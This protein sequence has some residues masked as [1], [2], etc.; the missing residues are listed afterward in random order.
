[1]KKT[2]LTILISILVAAALS[3]IYFMT[4]KDSFAA[5]G[6]GIMGFIYIGLQ[7][8][9]GIALIRAKKP[10]GQGLIIGAGVILLIGFS[11]CTML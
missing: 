11:V 3:I 7:L 2:I 10:I 9:A 5:I 8:I 4:N 1:M 6:W